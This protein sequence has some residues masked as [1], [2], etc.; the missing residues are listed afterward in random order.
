MKSCRY[1]VLLVVCFVSDYV[2]V[3]GDFTFFCGERLNPMY[4]KAFTTSVY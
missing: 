3:F 2:K 1:L 4:Q